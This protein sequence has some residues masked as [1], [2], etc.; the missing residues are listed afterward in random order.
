MSDDNQNEFLYRETELE[1]FMMINMYRQNP[2]ELIPL[3]ES[4]IPR[5]EGRIYHPRSEEEGYITQEGVLVVYEAIDFIQK[6]KQLTPFKFSKGLYL[7]AK[8]HL[9]DIGEKGL[10]S[11]KGSNG[12]NLSERV[13]QFGQW[14]IMVAENIGFNDISAEDI[15]INF[16]LDD[17]NVN[18]GHRENLFNENLGVIGVTC[19][20]HSGHEHCSVLNFAGQM[21][22][23]FDLGEDNVDYQQIKKLITQYSGN[24][25]LNN[26]YME[27]NEETG[28][29][30]ESY[31]DSEDEAKEEEGEVEG[32]EEEVEGEEGEKGSSFQEEVEEEKNHDN[33]EED[34]HDHNNNEEDNHDHNNDEE[35]DRKTVEKNLDKESI[36]K[37]E[38]DVKNNIKKDVYKGFDSFKKK[39]PDNRMSIKPK[40]T[41]DDIE[42]PKKANKEEET[43]RKKTISPIQG[44]YYNNFITNRK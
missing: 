32:E 5:F 18:R 12:S 30:L 26:L 2:K 3:L 25:I 29:E 1:L 20:K 42:T 23:Y 21:E 22:E 37:E 27:D 31:Q 9:N 10:A 24:E 14:R 8:E 17:G 40:K 6:Q 44:N 15:L 11:H 35:D 41:I 7:A 16:I 19:G 36:Q 39:I 43:Y 28:E 4:L 13:D 33:N 34:N 38:E